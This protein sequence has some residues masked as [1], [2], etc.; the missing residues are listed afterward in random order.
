MTILGIFKRKKRTSAFQ[1]LDGY[2]RKRDG[3]AEN[4]L[5]HHLNASSTDREAEYFMQWVYPQKLHRVA[6]RTPVGYRL[7]Y[8]YARD[9]WNNSFAV[10]IPDE[11][12]TSKKLNKKLIPYLRS[13]RWFKEMEKLSAYEKEQ[14]E[15]ILLLYYKDQGTLKNF[16]NK[17]SLNDEILEVEAISP[18]D[19]YIDKWKNGK[20]Q[21]YRVGVKSGDGISRAIE[22]VDIH[23]SR[24]LRKYGNEYEFR[25]QGYAD[26]AP[27]YDAIVI[28]STILKAAGEAAFRWGTGHPVFFTKGLVTPA[29]Y[30]ELENKLQD[31]TRRDWHL[32]PSELIDHIDMLGQAG[33]M[34]NIKSLADIAVENIIMGTGFPKAILLGE[35][36][37]VISGSEVNE[38]S[39]FALLDTDHSELELIVREYFRRDKNIRTLFKS[40]GSLNISDKN[41]EDYYDIDWGIR[42]VLNK[43]DQVEQEQKEIANS[44]ALTQ[45][46]TVDEVRE[47]MGYPPIGPDNYGD[48][49]QGLEPFYLFELQTI[50]QAAMM[51]AEAEMNEQTNPKESN[52]NTSM[53]QTAQGTKKSVTST[54]KDLEKNKSIKPKMTDS[55]LDEYDQREN[56]IRERYENLESA[57]KDLIKLKSRNKVSEDLKIQPKTLQKITENIKIKRKKKDVKG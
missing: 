28:L 51:G 31:L 30:A 38:R 34:L 36:A 19:Y 47:R 12:E 22:W 13:R 27:V 20:P 3:Y 50:V 57:F 11:A 15:A 44:L 41:T 42:Q 18:L 21:N 1:V 52:T 6:L 40:F 35:S 17:V 26:L 8:G 37:G 2:I 33:S 39:Y 49:V 23:P 5:A 53:K 10:K 16:I 4:P 55:K 48:V 29:E 14:G 43:K 32:I 45:V 25:Y 46:L 56:Q 9:V 24:V 7:T 54:Q